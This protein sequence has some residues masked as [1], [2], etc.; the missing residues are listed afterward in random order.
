MRKRGDKY[1]Q[2]KFSD[3]G[4][5]QRLEYLNT[6]VSGHYEFLGNLIQI[7]YPTKE[8]EV[9]FEELKSIDVFGSTQSWTQSESK[10]TSVVE[11]IE[12]ELILKIQ[13]G[14]EMCEGAGEICTHRQR[15]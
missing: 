6:F 5:R 9:A 10:Y 1:I 12:D 8:L 3:I 14:L 2:L 11:G 13:K 15:A 7:K 4:L